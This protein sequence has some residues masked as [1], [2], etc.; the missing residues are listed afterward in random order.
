MKNV[1]IFSMNALQ[2]SREFMEGSVSPLEVTE[3]CLEKAFEQSSPIYIK[4]TQE[5]ALVKL[6]RRPKDGKLNHLCRGW[7]EFQL[8]GKI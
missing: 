2:I 8:P 5:R 3:L 7:M 6:A 4:I 1:N